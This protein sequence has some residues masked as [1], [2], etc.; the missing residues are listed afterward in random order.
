[1]TGVGSAEGTDGWIVIDENPEV[2]CNAGVTE[3]TQTE[4]PELIADSNGDCRVDVQDVLLT[5]ANFGRTC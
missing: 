2:T 4:G 5:L 3:P 1:M